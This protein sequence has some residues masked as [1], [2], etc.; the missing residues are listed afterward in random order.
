MSLGG[1]TP[2]CRR[3]ESAAGRM[4]GVSSILIATPLHL[5]TQAGGWDWVTSVD[6]AYGLPDQSPDSGPLP[7]V[8][9]VLAAFRLAG[10]HGDAWFVVAEEL[11]RETESV[12][13]TD[14]RCARLRWFCST[15]SRIAV[16]S[17]SACYLAAGD[18]LD[19][20]RPAGWRYRDAA[21]RTPR[22]R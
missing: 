19:S 14:S 2:S 1:W 7:T 4:H 6:N 12:F 20:W 22:T 17:M 5:V 3:S 13:A 16:M 10:C 15:P 11:A 21:V 18:R 9:D 8:A